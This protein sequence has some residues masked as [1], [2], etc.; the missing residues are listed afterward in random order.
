[1]TANLLPSR[2]D[3]LTELVPALSPQ[4]TFGFASIAL[5][6]PEQAYFPTV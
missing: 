1:M 5:I 4:E 6:S 3:D 2:I